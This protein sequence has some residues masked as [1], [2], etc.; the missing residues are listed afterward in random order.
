MAAKA[1]ATNGGASNVFLDPFARVKTRAKVFHDKQDDLFG[2]EPGSEVGSKEGTPAP[3]RGGT[4]ELKNSTLSSGAKKKLGV[5]DVVANLG[6]EIE[7]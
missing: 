6:L 2:S 5:D 1:I 7:I 4:P 3:G